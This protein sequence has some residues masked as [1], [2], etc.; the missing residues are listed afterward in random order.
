MKPL[1]DSEWTPA[2]LLIAAGEV[3]RD[4]EPFLVRR[5]KVDEAKAHIRQDA[6]AEQLDVSGVA[7]SLVGKI[8]ADYAAATARG[9]DAEFDHQVEDDLCGGPYCINPNCYCD[10]LE[11][12]V[13]A[14]SKEVQ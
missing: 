5:T 13:E 11:E 7:L 14:D 8:M 9:F 6:A 12:D 4:E 10:E 1:L 3:I 2:E